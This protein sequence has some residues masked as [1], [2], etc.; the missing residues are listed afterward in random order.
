LENIVVLWFDLVV[1]YEASCW[2][3]EMQFWSDCVPLYKPQLKII[4]IRENCA[5]HIFIQ[6]DKYYSEYASNNHSMAS[7]SLRGQTAE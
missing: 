4:T 7:F 1:K 5:G 6:P 3:I 2:E